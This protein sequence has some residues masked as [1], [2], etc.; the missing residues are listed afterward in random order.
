MKTDLKN[1]QTFAQRFAVVDIETTGS[2]T[3][4]HGITE[5]AIYLYNG[6]EIVDQWVSLINPGARI[7]DYITALTGI[8][9][10]M[11]AD[12]PA[13]EA[14]AHEIDRFTYGAIFVAH[15]VNFDYG[16]IHRAMGQAGLPFSRPKLCT[17][18]LSRKV[19]PGLRSYSL[20]RLCEHFGINIEARHRAWGDAR[21][22]VDLL[23]LILA[24]DQRGLVIQSLKRG[25][26]EKSLPPNLSQATYYRIPG[27]TGIYYFHNQRGETLYIGM[28]S[29]LRKRINGHFS[30]GAKSRTQQTLFNNIYDISW[31]ETGS[32]LVAAL[33]EN[34][35]IKRLWPPYNRALKKQQNRYGLYHFVGQD[36]Y[37]RLA[38]GAVQ[39]GNQP[40]IAYATE[41]EGRYDLKQLAALHG[42]CPKFCGLQRTPGACYDRQRGTCQGAC[43]Q[44]ESATSYNQKV[45][46]AIAS[47]TASQGS[48]LLLDKGRAQGE[49]SVVWI[50]R[51]AYAGFGFIPA[52]V[53]ATNPDSLL[54]YV[55]PT[56][57]D[58]DARKLIASYIRRD[59]QLK[60][61]SL[62][63]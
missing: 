22:T 5:V 12:A 26:Q 45:A 62:D 20:G 14:V 54:H 34:A 63:K 59:Y 36:G 4:A 55:K 50:D 18:R 24:N 48:F 51:G 7:P 35:E 56:K 19:F 28:A 37:E 58:V 31:E 52:D 10:D 41:P 46:Q 21:A 1:P 13:F 33:L 39:K 30:A 44:A 8:S 61:I 38:L 3:D 23:A 9:N 11:V 32:E 43:E 2:R 15:N 27:S 16:F 25:S 60:C 40:I 57:D 47:A 53:S 6:L 49:A 17:A 29:N 42:L